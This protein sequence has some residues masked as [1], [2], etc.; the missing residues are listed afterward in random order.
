MR[1]L[2]VDDDHE[3]ANTLARLLV[4]LADA[5]VECRYD[6]V[7]AVEAATAENARFDVLITDIEM[8][9][10][11]G[12]TAVRT[13]RLALGKATPVTIAASGRIGMDQGA[14][15]KGT[16][17]H[18]LLKPLDVDLLVKLLGDHRKQAVP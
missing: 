1:V 7:A 11:D 9:H 18:L 5:E 16:F 8:P 6:G 14:Q 12:I 13:I 3:S 10:M 15:L 17:D 4:M 2:V